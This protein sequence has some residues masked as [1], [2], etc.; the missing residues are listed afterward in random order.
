MRTLER[1]TDCCRHVPVWILKE[2][3]TFYNCRYLCHQYHLRQQPI[4]SEYATKTLQ[5]VAR[6]YPI[7]NV[8]QSS[9]GIPIAVILNTC[10]FK[11]LFTQHSRFKNKACVSPFTVRSSP[12]AKTVVKTLKS[13]MY[14]YSSRT[15]RTQQLS[16]A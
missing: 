11:W 8:T 2:Q 9:I 6:P 14:V 16:A 1:M 12:P 13:F 4:S 10:C 15:F 7:E 5:T 3:N